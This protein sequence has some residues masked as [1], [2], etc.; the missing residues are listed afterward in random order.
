MEL[1]SSWFQGPSHQLFLESWYGACVLHTTLSLLVYYAKLS[2]LVRN[3]FIQVQCHSS[4]MFAQRTS[5]GLLLQFVL[6]TTPTT[7]YVLMFL[8]LLFLQ[9]IPA[10]PRHSVQ[11]CSTY[12]VMPILPYYYYVSLPYVVLGV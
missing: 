10:A 11:G 9:R 4:A 1:P 8:V 2:T 5:N 12:E 7:T 6:N 3:S